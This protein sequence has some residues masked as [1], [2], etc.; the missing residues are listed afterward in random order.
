MEESMGERSIVFVCSGNTDRS[1]IAE[2]ILK[3]EL[4]KT[5]R[6][7]IKVS[8]MGTHSTSGIPSSANAIA[9]C[10]EHGIDISGHRSRPLIPE[11]L[12]KAY[13]VLCMESF[14][15]GIV[16][17]KAPEAHVNLLS[18]WLVTEFK[19]Y[20]LT[21]IHDPHGG[22]MNVYRETFK[23]IEHHIDRILPFLL[24]RRKRLVEK[25]CLFPNCGKTFFGEKGKG[26]YCSLHQRKREGIYYGNGSSGDKVFPTV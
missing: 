2:G 17:Q 14:H 10:S 26:R 11:E 1:P 12:S 7:D 18:H 21:E 25:V 24:K 4:E 15:K 16:L 8:S 19:K 3:H 6:T 23:T 13:L 22:D 20:K 5:G 9:V